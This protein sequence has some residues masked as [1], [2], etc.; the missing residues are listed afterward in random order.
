M[1]HM[2]PCIQI[3]IVLSFSFTLIMFLFFCLI[4]CITVCFQLHNL[5]IS[6]GTMNSELESL[7]KEAI[8]AY[9]LYC[10]S[11]FLKVL[12][13]LRST[14]VKVTA[15]RS[16]ISEPP[17]YEAGL[18][19]TRQRLSGSSSTPSPSPYSFLCS[20]P[21]TTTATDWAISNANINWKCFNPLKT[22]FPL[23]NIYKF[24]PYLTGN[25]LRLH[26]KA[27]PVNAVWGNSRCLLW[28]PYGTHRY[29]VWAECRVLVC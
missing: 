20:S 4:G 2:L 9:L 19:A 12:K 22:E 23:N 1:G 16:D 21:F 18:L 5:F 13:K 27:Q 10:L 26:Y 24:S 11:I 7:W 29:I 3:V 6:N 14:T 28:E 25:T 17:G 8:V 15:L